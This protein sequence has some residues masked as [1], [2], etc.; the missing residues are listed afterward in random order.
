MRC[1]KKKFTFAISSP[2]EFLYLD[3]SNRL[4]LILQCYR[5]DRQD[6]TVSFSFRQTDRQTDGRATAISR[7]NVNVSS[8]SLK[9]PVLLR[10]Q[11]HVRPVGTFLFQNRS[12]SLRS[13]SRHPHIVR[14]P[15]QFT[16]IIFSGSFNECGLNAL[17]T[18]PG[19]C[20]SG[21]RL[22]LLPYF[23]SRVTTA[24]CRDSRFTCRL[25]TLGCVAVVKTQGAN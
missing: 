19:Q 7:A 8:R 22:R 21:H 18:D 25:Y 10:R 2:D 20:E 24:G 6:C 1:C 23:V 12:G 14:R 16:S 3:P 17:P 9:K 11:A 15:V 5:Q 4:A 13:C